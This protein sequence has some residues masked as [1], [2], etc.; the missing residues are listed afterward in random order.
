MPECTSNG[1]VVVGGQRDDVGPD[2]RLRAVCV[3]V[4]EHLWLHTS[5][6]D[7]G[8][9]FA[10]DVRKLV[11]GNANDR[12]VLLVELDGLQVECTFVQVVEVP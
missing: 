12:A 2:W 7:V 11:R 5:S 3:G 1:A 6:V 8:P 9:C 10:V 4:L